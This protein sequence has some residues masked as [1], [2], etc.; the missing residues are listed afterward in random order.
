MFKKKSNTIA[1]Y[2]GSFDPPHIGHEAVVQ[3]LLSYKQ[4]D[5]VL[6]MPTFLNPF[7]EGSFA[8][9]SL[10]LAWLQKMFKES[11]RVKVSSFEVDLK[12]KVPSIESVEY[13]L[14]SYKKIYFVIGADN[15]N[16]LKSWYKTEELHSK[17]SFI[18]AQRNGIKVPDTYL[19]LNV[20]CDVSSSTLREKMD[21]NR[22]PTVVAE[23]I[24]QYYKD[25][26]ER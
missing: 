3:E 14:K 26:N 22:L 17:V 24:I 13:L 4:I 25:I 11:P 9:A 23:S 16:S 6:I 18:V 19:T 15:L 7:K 10:R 1:L 8:P 2:G 20:D 21:K 5:E 12:R